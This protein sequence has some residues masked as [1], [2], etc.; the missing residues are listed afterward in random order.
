MR[1][2]DFAVDDRLAIGCVRMNH[3]ITGKLV[4]HLCYGW[5]V[6]AHWSRRNSLQVMRRVGFLAEPG[7]TPSTPLSEEALWRRADRW[8]AEGWPLLAAQLRWFRLPDYA[9]GFGVERV[10]SEV[11]AKGDVLVANF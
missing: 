2:S 3:D 8:S 10:L 7:E 5:D 11:L 9:E 6:R 1:S 4:R